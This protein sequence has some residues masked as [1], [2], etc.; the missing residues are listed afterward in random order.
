MSALGR[1]ANLLDVGWIVYPSETSDHILLGRQRAFAINHPPPLRP[2]RQGIEHD[3]HTLWGF[4]V[5]ETRFVLET[6]GM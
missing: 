3:P 6:S 2:S 1:L 4:R 5:A